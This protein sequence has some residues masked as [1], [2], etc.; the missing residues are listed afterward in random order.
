MLQCRSTHVYAAACTE[1]WWNDYPVQRTIVDEARRVEGHAGPRRFGG[2]VPPSLAR[3]AFLNL[4]GRATLVALALLST[5]IVVHALG[6]AQYGVYV[7][8]LSLGGLL[9]IL[10]LGLTPA[11][12][13]LLSRAWHEH[14]IGTMQ[15]ATSTGFTLFLGIGLIGGGIMALLVP[16][17]A[18]T[19]LHLPASTRGAARFALWLST[20]AFVLNMW[21]AVFSAV[22]IALERYDLVTARVIGVSLTSTIA[23]IVCVLAGGGLQALMVVNILTSV[24]G[25]LLFYAASRR[26]LPEI[27]LRPGFDRATFRQLARFSAFKFVGS[28]S[29]ILTFRFDQFAIGALMNVTAVGYYAVPANASLRVFTSLIELIQ[30]L[31]PRISKLRGDPVLRRSL[32]LRGARVMNLTSLGILTILLVFADRVL[33]YWIHGDQGRVIALQS[34]PAFRWLLAA[35]IIQ[36]LA[37][38][39]ATFSE[40]LGR[41]EI[42]N[43]FSVAGALIHVPLVLILVPHFGITGAALALFIN[44]A[45]QTVAFVVYASRSMAGVG[46]RELV[47]ETLARPAAGAAIA[48]IG[49]F[50]LR[51]LVHGLSTLL[52]MV[53][54]SFVLYVVGCIA[55]SAFLL[56]DVRTLG[57]I[58]ERLPTRFP[59]RA[60]LARLAHK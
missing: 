54:V 55:F 20:G 6:T 44:S 2:T 33:R 5:P 19:L 11:I 52:L 28:V 8:A 56:E 30:P 12:I 29:G 41:P 60:R 48:A 32:F 37:A 50:L 14:E 45:T 58:A 7:L 43:I 31:F 39:P 10:D 13:M 51:P 22:P 42:N 25:L 15:R 49:A 21:L 16:W 46:V 3:N 38:V 1:K 18:D 53:V 59:G 34:T 47:L 4:G 26:L 57:Q 17:M 9:N 35:F 27:R 36:S 40:A 23:I 24:A